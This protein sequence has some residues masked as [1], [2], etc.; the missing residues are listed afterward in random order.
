MQPCRICPIV[1]FIFYYIYTIMISKPVAYIDPSAFFK[2]E[3]FT[4]LKIQESAQD[5]AKVR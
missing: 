5:F 3:V 2:L 1:S 4:I